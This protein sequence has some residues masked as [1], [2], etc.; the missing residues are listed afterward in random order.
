[1]SATLR[2]LT[3]RARITPDQVGPPTSG[4]RR[5][6]GLRRREVASPA[7]LSVGAEPG[8]QSAQRL[9]LLASRAAPADIPLSNT[10]IAPGAGPGAA[11]TSG[12]RLADW[13]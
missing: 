1:M 4:S 12:N 7:G 3:R 2:L 10:P 13:P 9:G 8:F 6:P 5:V 11:P